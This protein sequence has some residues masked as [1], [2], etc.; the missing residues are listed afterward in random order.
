VGSLII[1]LLQI[2]FRVFTKSILKVVQHLAKLEARKLIVSSTLCAVLLKDEEM[3]RYNV[4]KARTVLT[5]SNYD[6][7]PR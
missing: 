5:A 3:P 4:R 7:G 1:A 2:Y 6:N